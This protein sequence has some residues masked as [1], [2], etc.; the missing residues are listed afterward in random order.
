MILRLLAWCLVLVGATQAAAADNLT[1]QRQAFQQL[2]AKPDSL[3]AEQLTPALRQYPLYPWLEYQIIKANLPQATNATLQ[4]FVTRYP[5]SLMADELLGELARRWAARQAWQ[6]LLTHIPADHPAVTTQCLRTQALAAT[7]QQEAAINNGKQVWQDLDKEIDAACR[8]VLEL[9]ERQHALSPDDYWQRIGVAIDKNQLTL[10]TQLAENQSA[11]MQAATSLWVAVRKTPAQ[12]A[13]ALTQPDNPYTRSVIADGLGRLAR[14]EAATV[15]RL[16]QQ[17]RSKF[18]FSAAEIGK[19]ESALGMQQALNHD[20]AAVARLSQIPAEHR[21]QD[22]NLWLARMAARLGDWPQVLAASQQLRFDNPRDAAPWQYWQARALEQQGKADEARKLY[23]EIADQASFY[24]F[25][26]ADRLGQGYPALQAAP[27]DRG[28]RVQGLQRVAALQRALEWLALGEREQGR[29]EW[30]RALKLMDKPGMVAAADLAIRAGEPNL[31]IWT[32]SRAKE[33]D[34][35]H[36]RF[37]LIHTDLVQQ[38]AAQH[39]IQPAWVLGVMRRE[40]A[41][42]PYAE[43][44][45]NAYG[46][47][48]VILPTAQAMGRKLG[49][50]IRS[51][52]DIFPPPTNVQLGAAYLSEMLQTFAGNYALA[53]A[54]Y[55]AGPAR[56]VKWAPSSLVSADQ[57]VES[58][59]FTETREYVQAVLTFTTIYD[60]KLSQG[61]GRRLSERLQPIAP[62]VAETRPNTATP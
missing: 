36:L 42:D 15:E 11:A 14:K 61:K 38:A 30:L 52:E 45:A 41:F 32:L 27:V 40:S 12:V 24:G 34:E 31:A 33:W 8:P 5:H 37:P 55:N 53:T 46:L 58:I 20:P 59:P 13:Q 18:K 22:G 9:L 16:W 1:A 49:L 44:S 47:M 29:K 23:T 48:Q 56:P 35:I 43:S 25:L 17:A 6:D 7:G 4:R 19:A 51:K 2:W 62:H 3:T 60:D 28:Q 57:W 10:A 21:S 26:A 54:A 50:T 39:G